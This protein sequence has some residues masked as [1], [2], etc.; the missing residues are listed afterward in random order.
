MVKRFELEEGRGE[1]EKK[2]N[3]QIIKSSNHQIVT[4]LRIESQDLVRVKDT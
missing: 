4:K 3:H 1:R 2:S